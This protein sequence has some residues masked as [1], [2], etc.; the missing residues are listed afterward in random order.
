MTSIRRPSV[1]ISVRPADD[2]HEVVAVK[3]PP[4]TA[5]LY[6]RAPCSDCPWRLDS[7]GVFPAEAFRHSANTAHDMSSHTFGCHQSGTAKSAVCAGFLMSGADN[8]L[9]VRIARITGEIG[10]DVSAGGQQ[11]HESYAAMATAN[12]VGSD[13]DVLRLCR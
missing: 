11:L 8:N 2:H 10:D 9:A 5:K 13:E 1:T 3:S 4:G 12:G 6:R 7:V